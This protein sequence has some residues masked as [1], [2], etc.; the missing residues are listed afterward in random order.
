MSDPSNLSTTA[1]D[2]TARKLVIFEA[3]D[4]EVVASLLQDM[5]VRVADIAYLERLKKFALVGSRYEWEN[6]SRGQRRTAAVQF[7]R[8]LGVQYSNILRDA[9]DAL[10]SLLSISFN[11][12]DA[13][14]GDIRLEFS[15]GGAI[16]LQAE[17]LEGQMED[18]GPVWSTAHRPDHG[19]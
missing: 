8:I 19:V 17:I 3:D 4:L 15:G 18:L 9:P 10:L 2:T 7:D 6:S 11:E 14:S 5:I 1:S 16:R 12:T 13:P